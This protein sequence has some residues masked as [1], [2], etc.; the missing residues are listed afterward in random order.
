M[1]AEYID[2]MG[3]DLMVVNAARVSHDK[4]SSWQEPDFG[5]PAN[6]T[7]RAR[8]ERLIRFLTTS[9]PQHWTPFGHPHICLRM[10]VPIFVERQL[11][12]SRVGFDGVDELIINEESRRY[13]DDEP[14]FFQPEVWRSRP[15]ASIKQGSGGEFQGLLSGLGSPHGIPPGDAHAMVCRNA[16][17]VYTSMISAGVAPEMA[18]MVLPLSMYTSWYWT[19]SLAAWARAA[20]LR[21]DKHAQKESRDVFEQVSAIIAPYFPV[22][23]KYLVLERIAPKV[24][25]VQCDVSGSRPSPEESGSPV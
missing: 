9:D 12:R 25:E 1:K 16:L 6:W 3:D 21:L 13:V 14:E 7:L 20:V 11:T 8:D 15:E 24:P 19:G 17:R 5:V 23:W 18:R 10:T 22:S 2:H 4:R